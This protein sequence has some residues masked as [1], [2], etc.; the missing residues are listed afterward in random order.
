MPGRARQDCSSP[1]G[2]RE[3]RP[4]VSLAS[5]YPQA[6]GAQA[7]WSRSL[8]G[9][10][11]GIAVIDSG[12]NPSADLGGARLVQV[13]LAGQTDVSDRYGHGTIVAGV[14]GGQSADGR[15]VGVAPGRDRLLAERRD[16]IE[17]RLHERHHQRARLG[18]RPRA[19]QQHQGCAPLRVS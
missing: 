1:A 3:R 12:T 17:R 18:A 7:A 15:Y 9:Q 8:N 2:R 13:S 14:V 5:V 11:V 16:A 6:I 10:G 4:N 19:D